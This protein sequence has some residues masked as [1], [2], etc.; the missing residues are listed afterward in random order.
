MSDTTKKTT[1]KKL[2]KPNLEE[3]A[4][5]GDGLDITED[6]V[7]ELLAPR[8]EILRTRG[9]GDL[10]IYEK[11]LRDDQ[12]IS[13]WQQRRRSAIA[14]EWFV[15]PGGSA[16]IDQAAADFLHEQLDRVRWDNTT[17]KMLS[18]VFNGCSVGECMWGRDGTRVTLDAVHVRRA[19]RFRFDRDGQLRLITRD[20]P[21]GMVMPPNKFWVLTAG[22]DDDDDYYGRGLGYWLYWPVW[23]KRNGLKFWSVYMEKYAMP[24]IKG[25]AP[26][27]ASDRERNKLL[28]V[29]RAVARDSAVVV[30]EGVDMALLEAARSSG[31]DYAKFQELMDAAIAKIILSQTMTTDNG[32]SLSQAQVHAD[33]KMEVVKSDNDLVCESFNS[34]PA[35][36]LT[37]WNFPGAAPPRVWRDHTEPEDLKARAERD[38]IVS[39]MGYEPTPEYI[40][41]TYGE[42]WTKRAPAPGAAISAGKSEPASFAEAEEGAPEQ[43]AEQLE[44]LTGPALSALIDDLGRVIGNAAD[45]ADLDGKL[46]EFAAGRGVDDLAEVIGRGMAAADLNGRGDLADGH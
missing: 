2:A 32:A 38:K 8:D 22:A 12:V 28:A 4:A 21:L 19:R 43:L 37:A 10:E 16:A 15:E 17:L 44:T 23:L 20:K 39:E 6:Y 3:V 42:G 24:T 41:E 45:L 29:L 33:V 14:R 13:C 11:V 36:W 35:V 27:G 5:A 7:S 25:V 30:P 1:T 9:R 34:G 40:A 31:G 18:G 26:R 46:L